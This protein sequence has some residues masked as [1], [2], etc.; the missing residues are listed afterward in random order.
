LIFGSQDKLAYLVNSLPFNKYNGFENSYAIFPPANNA[1]P[2][3]KIL[4]SETVGSFNI[5]DIATGLS[6]NSAK[7]SKEGRFQFAVAANLSFSKLT[8][9]ALIDKSNYQLPANY[10]IVS[11]NKIVDSNDETLM[12]YTHTFTLATTSLQNEQDVTIRCKPP[13]VPSW[14]AATSTKNDTNPTG[15][16]QQ[17]QTFG[18]EYVVNGL[19]DA[20]SNYYKDKS[21][22]FTL[23][24][25]ISDADKV[26][27]SHGSTGII[28]ISILIIIIIAIIIKARNN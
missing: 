15:V 14:V 7:A 2:S 22:E 16:K 4:L 13:K 9:D 10:S 20:Y 21:N 28:V 25:K 8:G 5:T 11:V 24:V 26:T 18:L 3:G 12:G 6:I 19:Y 17:T 23:T 27:G 1:A